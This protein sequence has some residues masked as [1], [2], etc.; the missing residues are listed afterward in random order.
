MTNGSPRQHYLSCHGGPPTREDLV[1]GTTIIARDTDVRRLVIL[2]ALLIKQRSPSLNL[3][4]QDLLILPSAKPMPYTPPPTN[5]Q[6]NRQNN[7]NPHAVTSEATDLTPT[8]QNS[9]SQAN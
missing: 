1:K 8:N 2:E 4:H 7:V 5:T 6:T 3:K 9:P